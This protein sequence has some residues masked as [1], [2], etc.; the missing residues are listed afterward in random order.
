MKKVPAVCKK[1]Y[2][3]SFFLEQRHA[4]DERFEVFAANRT[5]RE[6]PNPKPPP[7][8]HIVS[9]IFFH[10]EILILFIIILLQADNSTSSQQETIMDSSAVGLSMATLGLVASMAIQAF[11]AYMVV[12]LVM[13]QSHKDKGESSLEEESPSKAR[14]ASSTPKKEIKATDERSIRGVN[15]YGPYKKVS[16]RFQICLLFR[17]SSS[18]LLCRHLSILLSDY[19]PFLFRSKYF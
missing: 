13:Q 10:R 5:N 14:S 8:Y 3:S 4:N 12:Q 1:T 9:L 15:V 11:T 17:G 7:A 19:P 16:R 18:H 2:S 6:L